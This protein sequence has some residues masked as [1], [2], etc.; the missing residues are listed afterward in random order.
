MP[1]NR[2]NATKNKS[3]TLSIVIK[4]GGLLYNPYE[5]RLVELYDSD[6]TVGSPSVVASYAPTNQSQ[7]VFS[8]TV[9]NNIL[10]SVGLWY[11]RWHFTWD[12]GEE[13][14]DV[15]QSF[16]VSSVDYLAIP[17]DSQQGVYGGVYSPGV[18]VGFGRTV[19][20]E[21]GIDLRNEIS[22]LCNTTG[23]FL[24]WRKFDLSKRSIYWHP[25]AKEAIS[26]PPWEYTDYVFKARRIVPGRTSLEN[27][28][29]ERYGTIERESLI[30]FVPH[31]IDIK[32]EDLLFRIGDETVKTAPSTVRAKDVYEVTLIEPKIDGELIYNVVKVK[33]KTHINDE[34]FRGTIPVTYV[35][36]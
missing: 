12:A 30:Y 27:E 24:G 16:Y 10:N 8:V 11:D 17:V 7:G 15:D 22:W 23:Y 32:R 29:L 3:C 31:N 26:G 5:V 2:G 9:P 33:V 13:E 35:P 28:I 14:I 25:I 36:V 18:S 34:T 6:P 19:V 21:Q 20:A 1:Y 4:R